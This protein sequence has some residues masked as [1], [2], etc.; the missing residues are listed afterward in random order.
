M[1]TIQFLSSLQQHLDDVQLVNRDTI[2]QFFDTLS[3]RLDDAR[4]CERKRDRELASRFNVLDY[5][6]TDEWGLSHIISDLL[7]PAA[8]HGQGSDFLRK[9]LELLKERSPLN[10]DTD[11]DH[12]QISVSTE[13]GTTDDRRIDIVVDIMCGPSQYALAIENKP[14]ADDQENQVCDYLRHLSKEYERKFLLIYFSPTGEGPSEKSISGQELLEDWKTHFAILPYHREPGRSF[15]DDFDTVRVSFSLVDWL[16]ACR[17]ECTVGRLQW[18]LGDAAKYCETIFGGRSVE[19]DTESKVISDYLKENPE[20]LEIAHTVYA[21]WPAIRD[22]VCQPFL[23]RIRSRIAAAEP[24]KPY[25]SD[26]HV[27]CRYG[28]G[29]RRYSNILWLYLDRWPQFDRV[30]DDFSDRR[31]SIAI[32][33]SS[34]GPTGWFVSVRSPIDKNNML[35]MEKERIERLEHRLK[36]ELILPNS[37]D[38]Y[39]GW[40]Y[41]DNKYSDWNRLVPELHREHEADADGEV[42]RGF[43]DTFVEVAVKAIPIINDIDH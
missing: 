26:M 4:R 37:E 6:R 2:V 31:I 39:P 36:K 25:A 20:L 9:L 29:G 41:M 14:F 13:Y 43:V 11:L 18:F 3:S 15:G 23:E 10:L 28:G 22:Q 24:L 8:T 21:S 35:P 34:R 27:R 38:W 40:K 19:S 7:N 5:L 33:S 16:I 17:D 42:T 1:D 32:E 30:Q 12:C